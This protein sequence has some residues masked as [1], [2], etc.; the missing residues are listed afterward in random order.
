MKT[1]NKRILKQKS[2][3]CENTLNSLILSSPIVTTKTLTW[4]QRMARAFT[5][6]AMPS[7][8]AKN[9]SSQI[10]KMPATNTSLSL[11]VKHSH[12]NLP[13]WK[14]AK[15]LL[16]LSWKW[17]SISNWFHSCQKLTESELFKCEVNMMNIPFVWH[18]W[19]QRRGK[20]KRQYL[21]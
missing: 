9:A 14:K 5:W 2:I 15:F 8:S 1:T 10:I 7:H 21:A 19:E 18:K 11:Y 20:S 4:R 16:I 17:F 3:G 13:Q 6:T 12:F